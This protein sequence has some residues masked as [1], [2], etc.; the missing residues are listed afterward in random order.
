MPFP[1]IYSNK[2]EA[3]RAHLTALAPKVKR[4]IRVSPNTI[5]FEDIMVYL[6][7]ALWIKSGDLPRF[8]DWRGNMICV[9]IY[10]I[11]YQDKRTISISICGDIA[12]EYEVF[13]Y[14]EKENE[15]FYHLPITESDKN[16]S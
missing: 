11:R 9:D 1:T 15:I 4:Q 5:Q 12:G 7:N 16:E 2:V 14:D 3:I 10:H 8:Y 13:F 6:Y